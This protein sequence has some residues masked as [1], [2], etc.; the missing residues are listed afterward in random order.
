MRHLLSVV[1]SIILAPLTYIAAGLAAVKLDAAHITSTDINWTAAAIGLGSGLVAGALYAVLVMARLSPLG[2][3]VAALLYLGATI[4][5]F[6]NAASFAKALDFGLFGVKHVLLQP[7]GAGTLLLAVPL[8]ATVFSRRRWAGPG[9]SGLPYDAAPGYQQAPG[10]AAPS[11]S[12]PP[13]LVTPTYGSSYPTEPDT[14]PEPVQAVYTPNRIE[15]EPVP[16]P[17]DQPT[18]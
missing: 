5:A 3:V 12:E 16:P 14:R 11:Y 1:L 13:T 9:E 8:F 6:L 10:T 17:P 4:W 2:P 15:R 7:V 18:P